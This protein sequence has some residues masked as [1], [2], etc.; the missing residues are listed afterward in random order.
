[1]SLDQDPPAE[2][3]TEQRIFEAAR[4]VFVERGPTRARMQDIAEEAGITSSLLHYY[5]RTRDQLFEQVFEK[6]V[7]RMIPRGRELIESDRPL[8]EKLRRFSEMLIRF[9]GEN[10]NL[11]IFIASESHYASGRLEKIK[12]AMR[13][14]DLSTVQA[15]LDR[16]AGAEDEAPLRAEDLMTNVLALSV[17]PF[18]ARPLLQAVLGLDEGD[19][20]AF[21]ARR[22]RSVPAFLAD[23]LPDEDPS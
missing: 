22:E 11:A 8:E 6:E 7:L 23:T 1:M 18:I 20:D 9:H 14:V 4:K 5:F 12:E 3:D 13:Q 2:R 17:F 15:Q 19:F 16:R 21:V 10:P